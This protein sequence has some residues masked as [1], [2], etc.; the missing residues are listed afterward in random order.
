MTLLSRSEKKRMKNS[1]SRTFGK[2]TFQSKLLR[3]RVQE[4][5]DWQSSKIQMNFKEKYNF[6]RSLCMSPKEDLLVALTT[7]LLLYSFA[8]KKKDSSLQKKNLFSTFLYPFHSGPIEG[9]DVC[10]RF[11]N[12]VLNLF[13][14]MSSGNL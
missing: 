2:S 14:L 4:L 7:D 6:C 1:A 3:R 11:E 12:W 5:R 13:P 9:L 10:H 8:L